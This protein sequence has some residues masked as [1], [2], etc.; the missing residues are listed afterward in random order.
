MLIFKFSGLSFIETPREI[1]WFLPFFLLNLVPY[2]YPPFFA[3]RLP[4]FTFWQGMASCDVKL[5]G[6]Q[7]KT[8]ST[9]PRCWK[10]SR[11]I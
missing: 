4:F 5:E 11:F 3:Y 8:R 10:K 1:M 7:N 9:P 6:K 2:M